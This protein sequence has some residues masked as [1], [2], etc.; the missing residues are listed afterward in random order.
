MGYQD[1]I[2]SYACVEATL[3]DQI[4]VL[5]DRIRDLTADKTGLNA[6][7]IAAQNERERLEHEAI[8]MQKQLSEVKT[9]MSNVWNENIRLSSAS[10][11]QELINESICV[12]E[13]ELQEQVDELEAK[14]QTLTEEKAALEQQQVEAMQQEKDVVIQQMQIQHDENLQETVAQVQQVAQQAI[15]GFERREDPIHG[16]RLA[17]C[18]GDAEQ[19][20]SGEA[21]DAIPLEPS[22]RSTATR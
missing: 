3:R 1:K 18:W 4:T 13:N 7:L 10:V 20:C 16:D 11:Q 15:A 17:S 2:V 5:E 22:G 9:E 6:A 21:H 14:V 8:N 12:E 19:L